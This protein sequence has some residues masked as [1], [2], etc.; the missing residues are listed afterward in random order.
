MKYKGRSLFE[1]DSLGINRLNFDENIKEFSATHKYY[2]IIDYK[3]NL[4]LYHKG[5]N[6]KEEFG[7]VTKIDFFI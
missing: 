2:G 6:L 1:Y 5:K 7:R 3:N 4:T